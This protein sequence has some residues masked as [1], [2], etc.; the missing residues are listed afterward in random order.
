[1]IMHRFV[2]CRR[3]ITNR[4]EQTAIVEPVDPLECGVFDPIDVAPRTTLPDHFG[5][6]QTVDRFGQRIMPKALS[7]PRAALWVSWGRRS[8]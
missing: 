6:V 5:L 3:Y 4:F 8:L 2:F 1:M 7:V